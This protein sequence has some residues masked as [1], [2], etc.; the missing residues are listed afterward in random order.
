MKKWLSDLR[1]TNKL[2]VSP[3]VALL[4]LMLFGAVTYL[5]FFKQQ[6]ALDDI[7]GNRFKEYQTTASINV[8]MREVHAGMQETMNTAFGIMDAIKRAQ[9]EQRDKGAP[10]NTTR[11]IDTSSVKQ[12]LAG[13]GKTIPALQELSTVVRQAIDSPG[14]GQ[15]EKE[16]LTRTRENLT[17]YEDSLNRAVEKAGAGDQ[18]TARSAWTEA[19]S[20]F[21]TITTDLSDLLALESKLS[22]SQY[23]S[24][25]AAFRSSASVSLIV[26]LTAIILP[27]VASLVMKSVILS[28]VTKTV[29]AI[30][31]VAAGD[32]TKRIDV[33]ARDEMGAMAGHFNSFVKKLHETI[34]HVAQSSTQVSQAA[35]VLESATDQMASGVEEAAMQINSVATASEEMS[36]T[37]SEIAQNCVVAVK[38]SDAA[39]QSVA[40]GETIIRQTISI[41]NRISERVRE[42]S[43]VIKTLG[44]RSDQIGQIVDLIN[45][46]ADQT[47]LLALNAAIEA[48]RAGEH[49]RGFAVVADEVRKALRENEQRHKRNLENDQGHA[50]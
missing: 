31:A 24:S 29:E 15:E 4:F 10:D 50:G 36:K 21:K 39:N 25:G 12:A 49:G 37:S 38:S 45:D 17:K 26:F 3:I 48:A 20:Q 19:N 11:S 16:V 6:S 32:L 28:P 23:A 43:E 8:G 44:T 27:L 47:N 14:L 35:G 33:M 9:K 34:T 41:M 40:T 46:V 1:M 42:S 2:L 7:I 30:E 5:G 13:A 22:E 18:A